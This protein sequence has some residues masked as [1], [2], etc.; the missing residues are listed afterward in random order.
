MIFTVSCLPQIPSFL[1]KI[2][3]QNVC[4][5]PVS[6]SAK[7]VRK[8]ADPFPLTFTGT[9]GS[10]IF[11]SPAPV[12]LHVTLPEVPGCTELALTNGGAFTDK[13]GALCS[14]LT[15]FEL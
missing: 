15:D 6:R 5:D 4:V 12:A 8:S 2:S 10:A 3:E 7:V 11:P 9:I 1:V 13:G 14:V